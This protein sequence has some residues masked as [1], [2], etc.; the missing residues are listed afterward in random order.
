MTR[1]RPN[2]CVS[3]S[4]MSWY[5]DAPSNSVA[6]MRWRILRFGSQPSQYQVPSSTLFLSEHDHHEQR[7]ACAVEHL[8]CLEPVE[9]LDELEAAREIDERAQ[10]LREDHAGQVRLAIDPPGAVFDGLERHVLAEDLAHGIHVVERRER[11]AKDEV[12]AATRPGPRPCGIRPRRSDVPVEDVEA[13][14]P[15]R[16]ADRAE[17]GDELLVGEQVP[18]RV[19]HAE[20]GVHRPAQAEVGHVAD[21]ELRALAFRGEAL[22]QE[23]DVGGREVEPGHGVAAVGE[24]GQ[25][26]P[27]AAGDVEHAAHGAARVALEAVDEE[28]DLALPVHVE[29]DLVEARRRVLAHP[30]T[31]GASTWPPTPPNVRSAPGNPWRSSIARVLIA[32]TTRAWPRESPRTR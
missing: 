32:P 31:W 9:P 28:V 6:R 8:V 30:F 3:S 19:L 1:S 13:A 20:C 27:R 16:S 10:L 7:V 29:G 14:T 26:W 23:L 25:V 24:T 17:V 22:A 18:L 4:W 21:D 12:P 11:R 15:E 5:S 2:P